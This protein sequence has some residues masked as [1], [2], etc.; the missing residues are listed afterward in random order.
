MRREALRW[1]VRGFGFALGVLVVAVLAGG[2]VLAGRVLVL[3]F[4]AVLLASALEPLVGRLRAQ[5]LETR[6]S[7]RGLIFCRH[8]SRVRRDSGPRPRTTPITPHTLA[9]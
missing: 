2:V 5:K 3:V 9:P 6:P 7:T 8:H 1:L 4:V